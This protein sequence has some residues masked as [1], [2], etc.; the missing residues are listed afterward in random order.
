ME[1]GSIRWRP[2]VCL[3]KDDQG[4][5]DVK[6]F[7]NFQDML[8]WRLENIRKGLNAVSMTEEYYLG[9]ETDE[10]AEWWKSVKQLIASL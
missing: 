9:L 4:I 6:R 1:Y 7:D 8:Q 10:H 5:T 3:L 2:W